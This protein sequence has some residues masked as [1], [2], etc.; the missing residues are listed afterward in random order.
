MFI[1]I[2]GIAFLLDN[3][4]FTH[5]SIRSQRGCAPDR[6]LPRGAPRL[7]PEGRAV[8]LLGPAGAPQLQP[9]RMS[10]LVFVLTRSPSLQ[11]HEEDEALGVWIWDT[12]Y[13]N[14]TISALVVVQYVHIAQHFA[15]VNC[16]FDTS[17]TSD[18]EIELGVHTYFISGGKRTHI[19]TLFTTPI[20]M[21]TPTQ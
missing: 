8:R 15:F 19:H 17:T 1:V 20:S 16:F 18:D 11:L 10:M 2:E 7:H 3:T 9:A 4:S 6:R 13:A 5:K 12:Y 21:L 14:E